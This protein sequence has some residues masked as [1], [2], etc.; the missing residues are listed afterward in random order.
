M[1]TRN[2]KFLDYVEEIARLAK[3]HTVFVYIDPFKPSQLHFRDMQAVY[4]H[5]GRGQSV[6]TLINFMSLGFL[7]AVWGLSS[8]AQG[9]QFSALS[10]HPRT[11]YWDE[12]AGG[13]YW[14]EIAFN[15][16]IPKKE[17]ADLL[18]GGYAKQLERWF[19]WVLT[20]P[21]R[22]KYENEFAKYHLIFG[23]RWHEAVDLMNRAMLK[24]RREFLGNR[25][26]KGHLFNMQPKKEDLDRAQIL[27]TV[28]EA[29][30]NVGKTT[31]AKL[32]AH[33]TIAYPNMCTDSDLNRAIK[34]A[35]QSG[36]LHSNSKADKI[37]NKASVWID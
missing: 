11:A 12:I 6:E 18:A 1:E 28:L 26:V 22:E 9:G 16:N 10:S 19:N 34:E 29:S 20:Y 4:D 32:R 24:A 30:R 21:V 5:L 3:T 2:G 27:S 37:E 33:A 15:E 8:A 36:K 35:I 23:S 25:F 13:S 31:W 14:Q 7:R 17:R